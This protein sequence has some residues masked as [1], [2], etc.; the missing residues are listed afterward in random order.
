M[1]RLLRLFG[2]KALLPLILVPL[3]IFASTGCLRAA[4]DLKNL[5][6]EVIINGIPSKTIGSFA[7]LAD[8]RLAATT[9]EL[10]ELG[11]DAGS[12][13]LANELVRLD[14]IPSLRYQYEERTQKIAITIDNSQRKG[15]N[16]D[17]R[18]GLSTN[19][20][21]TPA[22]FGGVLNYD[23]LSATPSFQQSRS[24]SFAGTSLTLDAR[25]FS[26][27]GTFNQSAIIRSIAGQNT[28]ALRLDTSYRYSD[29]ERLITYRAGDEITGGLAWT[30]SIR[31]G[32]L[33]AQRNFL[34]R[35]DLVTVPLPLLGGTAAVRR[36][37]S[38]SIT[39]GLSR[40]MSEPGRSACRMC[41]W[42][43]AQATRASWCATQPGM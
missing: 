2:A 11:I 37:I 27:Y 22:G 6:L 32:G 9:H 16:Y 30:R 34:L 14:D 18:A 24:F 7:Q 19:L 1:P 33:Q 21:R 41:R 35:P 17:L 38:T 25:A 3:A 8:G 20:P 42:F 31:I 39:S 29:P 23:L 36:W 13:R 43:R 5:Q 10:E 40:R 15:R 26:P 4:E 12:R 28:E